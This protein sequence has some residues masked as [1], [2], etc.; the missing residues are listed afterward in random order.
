[1]SEIDVSLLYVDRYQLNARAVTDIQVLEPLHQLALNR[2]VEQPY[3]RAFGGRAGDQ[4]I[5]LLPDPRSKE[6]RGSGFSNPAFYFVDDI[7]FLCAMLGQHP[8][9]IVAIWR[10]SSFYGG[11]Q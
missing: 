3:P 8:Q 1:M 7:L 4:G 9:F 6:K 5:E 10:C 11:L 2:H